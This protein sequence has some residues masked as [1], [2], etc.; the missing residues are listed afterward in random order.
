MQR[1]LRGVG[2]SRPAYVQQVALRAPPALPRQTQDRRKS[3]TE[4][5]A[6]PFI[7]DLNFNIRV[8]RSLFASPNQPVGY[9]VDYNVS[10]VQS[11]LIYKTIYKEICLLISIWYTQILIIFINIL[12]IKFRYVMSIIFLLLNGFTDFDVI[13]LLMT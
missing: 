1:L 4:H 8:I 7:L 11:F 6:L 5:T 10:I 3:K 12:Y 2:R 9:I 13:L